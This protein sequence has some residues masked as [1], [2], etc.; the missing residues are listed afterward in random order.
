MSYAATGVV[1]SDAASV[2][3]AGTERRL[4]QAGEKTVGLKINGSMFNGMWEGGREER[5]REEEV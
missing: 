4:G 5:E 2:A 3:S 1:V